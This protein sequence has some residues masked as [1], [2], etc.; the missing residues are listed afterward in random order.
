MQK[1]ENEYQGCN[2]TNNNSTS[3]NSP[4]EVKCWDCAQVGH[5]CGDIACPKNKNSNS[6]NSNSNNIGNHSDMRLRQGQV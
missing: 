6:N 1:H 2:N 4:N 3:N 5:R